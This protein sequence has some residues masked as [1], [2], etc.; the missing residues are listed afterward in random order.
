L[1][2]QFGSRHFWA[3]GAAAVGV[4]ALI[5]VY[6]AGITTVP[7]P[8]NQ[9]PIQHVIVVMQENRSFDNYFWTWPG[10]IGYNPNLCMP[11]N[12]ANL[13][14]AGCMKPHPASST[15]LKSDLPHTWTSSWASYNNGSMNGFLAADHGN[16]DVMSYYD[17]ASLPNLWTY[18]KDYVLADQFFSSVMSY[19]QPNHWYMIAGASPHVSLF[20]GQT[21]ERNVCYN[22]ATKQLT[23]ATC[24]YINQAQ[25][26][27]TMADALNA[28]GITWK[29]YDTPI[30]KGATLDQAIIGCKGCNPWAYWNPLDAKNSS[31]TNPAYTNSIVGRQQFFWDIGNGTLPQVSWIIPSGAISDHPPANVTLGMWWVTDVVN[32]VM[33]SKYWQNTALIV[34]WDEYG[35]FFDT[36]VPPSVDGNGLGFRAP[37]LIISAYAKSGYLDHTVYDFESTLKFIEWRFGIPSLTLRDAGANNL[38]NAFDFNQPPS[39]PHVIPLT[40]LQLT[41]IQPYIL[42]GSVNP[43]P[44]GTAPPALPFIDGNPD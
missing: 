40:K 8:S 35:G 29:Y 26:I 41:T 30:P 36:V 22:S 15:A 23:L 27:W 2:F 16:P 11:L 31:Y 13:S 21:Q 38:L 43:N 6:N 17:N 20:Q 25:Q 18:A 3:L 42:E 39:P 14:A 19:S 37:A 24:D 10:Q 44:H 34:T 9:N 32:A 33:Q 4:V 28:N 7:P 5:V 1:A 12:P